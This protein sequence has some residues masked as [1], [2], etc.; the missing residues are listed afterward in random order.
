MWILTTITLTVSLCCKIVDY[1]YTDSSYAVN[2]DLNYKSTRSDAAN[3]DYKYTNTSSALNVDY[4][5]TY[6]SYAVNIFTGM[7]QSRMCTGQ[8]LH[9]Q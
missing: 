7:L 9:S 8:C 2:V 5:Y 3:V 1:N 6:R 4:N